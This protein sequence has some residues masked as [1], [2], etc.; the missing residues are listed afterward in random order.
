MNLENF[1]LV[2]LNAQEI[3][4]VE[5]GLTIFGVVIFDLTVT[6]VLDG[7]PE[8]TQSDFTLFGFKLW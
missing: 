1:N 4:K 8:N 6:G 5:G 2:G 3:Q 7:I